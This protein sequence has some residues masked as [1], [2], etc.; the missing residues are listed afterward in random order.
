MTAQFSNSNGGI[1]R[2][3]SIVHGRSRTTKPRPARHSFS[4]SRSPHT[5]RSRFAITR[6][7]VEEIST[8]IHWRPTVPA[9]AVIA[10]AKSVQA[11]SDQTFFMRSTKVRQFLHDHWSEGGI[12]FTGLPSLHIE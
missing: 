1:L 12:L 8:P 11:E 3:C 7:A 9:E 10:P 4:S 5:S 2:S 6:Q